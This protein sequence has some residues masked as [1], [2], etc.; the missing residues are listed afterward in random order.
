MPAPLCIILDY[1]QNDKQFARTITITF[2]HRFLAMW[3]ATPARVFERSGTFV[4]NKSFCSPPVSASI[5][6]RSCSLKRECL[7]NR[8]NKSTNN[9]WWLELIHCVSTYLQDYS[10]IVSC[11]SSPRSVFVVVQLLQL[12]QLGWELGFASFSCHSCCKG[13]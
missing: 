12:L 6:S 7:L 2:L 13:V 11:P 8:L 5:P 10:A 9:K 3:C 1:N 4:P